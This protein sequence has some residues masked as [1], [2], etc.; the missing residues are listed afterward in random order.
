MTPLSQQLSN[1]IALAFLLAYVALV[2]AP[3]LILVRTERPTRWL[4]LGFALAAVAVRL[5]RLQATPPGLS[6]DDAMTLYELSKFRGFTWQDLF[7]QRTDSGGTGWCLL[8][9]YV[10]YRLS[11]SLLAIRGAGM[12]WTAALVAYTVT[13]GAAWFGL[14]GGAMA[15]A[16]ISFVPWS[17]FLS[18]FQWGPE[19]MLQQLYLMAAVESMGRKPGWANIV[20]CGLMLT[21]LQLT[22]IPARI[23]V[24]L[25][26]LFVLL[27]SRTTLGWR[28]IAALAAA[29]VI[30]I[31]GVLPHVLTGAPDFWGGLMTSYDPQHR[32]WWHMLN[33]LGVVFGS[34]WWPDESY[35][36][37]LAMKGAQVLPAIVV[38]AVAVGVLAALR[39]PRRHL[40]RAL[41]LA[42][43]AGAVPSW[44]S[45]FN[46]G[47]SH[48]MM[49]MVVPLAL[50]AGA[51]TLVVPM[52]RRA[53]VAAGLVA[54]IAV[55]GVR[56]WF[57]AE[58]WTY[59]M[60]AMRYG[61]TL[62]TTLQRELDRAPSAA[63]RATPV[64]AFALLVES[65]RGLPPR[66]LAMRR[67]DLGRDEALTVVYLGV[68][69]SMFAELERRGAATVE[70]V[71]SDVAVVRLPRGAHGALQPLPADERERL[72][73]L[74]T[75]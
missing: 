21:T 46:A 74:L 9:W 63:V 16:V 72:A 41:L 48:R 33:K 1:P 12:V 27:R 71:S 75:Q 23:T 17:V 73:T 36:G 65:E 22:Y 52:R 53:A 44:V 45:A 32:D 26:L 28:S 60:P 6:N 51:A 10:P 70:R 39:G 49:M 57:S 3:F 58:Y 47:H 7:G 18:R 15:A 66:A 37:T 59:V 13:V 2:A 30:A 54:L 42:V 40:V 31:V 34:L 50:L 29:Y 4:A 61:F 20:V 56:T 55:S 19:I 38:A 43:L 67:E 5:P 68:E 24:V 35:G 8:S 69:P 11:G 14:A 25:P 62:H 64:E